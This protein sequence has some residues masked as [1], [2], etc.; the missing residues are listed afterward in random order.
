MKKT[1]FKHFVAGETLGE[2]VVASDHLRKANM[3]V[4]LDY[5]VEAGS[6]SKEEL[7]RVASDIIATVYMAARDPSSFSVVKLSGMTSFALLERL[8]QIITYYNANPD[9]SEPIKLSQDNNRSTKKYLPRVMPPSSQTTPPA[10]LTPEEKQ[11]LAEL[12]T[13]VDSICS[14][15]YKNQVSVLF[16]AEQTYYQPA[17]DYLAIHFSQKYNKTTPIIYNT[18]QMYLRDGPKRLQV[19]VDNAKKEGYVLGVKLVR[20]AY[21]HTERQRARDMKYTDPIASNIQETHTNY[22][23]GLEIAFKNLSNVGV[24]ICSHNED[25]V[26]NA[27]GRLKELTIDPKSTR[28]QFAQ[29]YGMGDHLSFL[30]VQ[31]GF[32]V[33]KYVPF[34]PIE[35]VMPYLIRRMQENRGFLGS[36]SDKERKLLWRELRRRLRLTKTST[37]T[38]TATAPTRGTL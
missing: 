22:S 28:V 6:G 16:D 8:S 30:V 26:I 19:D 10:P 3:G 18:Y 38:T 23:T 12:M 2:A 24:M 7:D 33:F 25:T 20:G 15:S 36:A 5:S 29:L 35:H 17:I 1:F 21:M 27:I 13:R 4:V 37:S 14:E 9:N 31:N 32:R 34:G 11:E